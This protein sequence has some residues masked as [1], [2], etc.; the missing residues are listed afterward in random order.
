[1]QL[2]KKHERFSKFFDKFPKFTSNLE[3]FGN[4]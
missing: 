3:H 4:I 2:S 1:M